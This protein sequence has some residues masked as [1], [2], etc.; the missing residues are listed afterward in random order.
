MITN[1]G[2]ALS[3]GGLLHGGQRYLALLRSDGSE[4]QDPA[5]QRQSV[6]FGPVEQFGDGVAAGNDQSVRFAPYRSD[7]KE[8][9]T[10]WAIID[11]SGETL[12]TGQLERPRQPLA[13]EGPFFEPGGIVVTAP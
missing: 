3:L 2:L 6:E 8:P 1:R 9:I 5:Y 12:V 13:L 11:G 4:E 10:G 7:A